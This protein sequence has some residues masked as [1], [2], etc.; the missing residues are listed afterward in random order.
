MRMAVQALCQRRQARRLCR[1]ARRRA[2]RMP[3]LQP[4]LKCLG[5][6][7]NLEVMITL[8]LRRIILFLQWLP[9]PMRIHP[10]RLRLPYRLWALACIYLQSSRQ[11]LHPPTQAKMSYPLTA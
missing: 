1:R 2:V 7:P 10:R 11:L 5:D 4:L 8:Y 3:E 6:R 9:M